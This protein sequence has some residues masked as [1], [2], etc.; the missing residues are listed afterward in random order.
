MIALFCK[1]KKI[2][3]NEDFSGGNVG[4]VSGKNQET[5]ATALGKC[6]TDLN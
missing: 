1:F 3:L 2:F 6:D 5:T 4:N